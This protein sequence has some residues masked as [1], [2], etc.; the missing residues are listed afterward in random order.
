M[1]ALVATKA[2]LLAQT[3]CCGSSCELVTCGTNYSVIVTSLKFCESGVSKFQLSF[4][5]EYIIAFNVCV[6]T[7]S[8][9]APNENNYDILPFVCLFNVD[10]IDFELVKSL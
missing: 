3:I 8:M 1:L 5:Q 9:L 4:D 6:P 10:L 2:Y 7:V